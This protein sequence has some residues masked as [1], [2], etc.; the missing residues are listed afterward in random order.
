MAL[1]KYEFVEIEYIQ[2]SPYSG[3]VYDFEVEEDHSYNVG[4]IAVHNSVCTTRVKTA[5]GYPSLSSIAECADAA[6]GYRRGLVCADGGCVDSG[7]VC[8]AFGAGADFVMLGG[9]FAGTDECDG[10]WEYNYEESM[11][12][13]TFNESMHMAH[14]FG[15]VG[16]AVSATGDARHKKFLKFYGMSSKEAMQ[17]HDGG[18]ASHRTEEGKCVKIPYK[19]PSGEVA[20]DIMGGLRS[21]CTY[22]GA[23]CLKE[24]PKC[25]TFVRVANGRTHNTVFGG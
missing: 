6:H 13:T 10:E 20:Q 24:L 9:M 2:V 23:T 12:S 16:S 11:A 21:C 17:K 19:G 7:D 1:S 4:G 22:V 8:R 5:V 15:W 3:K 25:C 14:G 18:V